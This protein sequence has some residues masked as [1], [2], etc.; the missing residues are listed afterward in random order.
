[1]SNEKY[2]NTPCALVFIGGEYCEVESFSI[3]LTANGESSKCD[4]EIL[5]QAIDSTVFAK[6]A[7]DQSKVEVIVYAGYI[8]D[9][10]DSAGYLA[11]VRQLIN[12]Q[13]ER[14]K[15]LKKRF[16]G[17]VA[18]PQWIFGEKSTV[19][20]SCFDWSQLLREYKW[21]KNLKDGDTEISRVISSIQGKLGDYKI[22]ADS[23]TGSQRLGE[24]D[25]D[26]NSRVYRAEGKSIWDILKEC[27]TKLNKNIFIEGRT[28]YITKYKDKPVEWSLYYLSVSNQKNLKTG[29]FFTEASF[30]YGEIGESS[31]GNVV[32]DLYSSKITKKGTAKATYVR[33]PENAPI[34]QNTLYIKR[35]AKI[36]AEESE[37]RTMAENI[38]KKY[39]KKVMTGDVQLPFANNGIDVYDLV[40]FVC[41]DADNQINFIKDYYFSVNSINETYGNGGY[42]QTIEIETDPDIS[43]NT[44][45]YTKLPAPKPVK[46][47]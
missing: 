22:K 26:S 19:K 35:Y 42:T 1:M 43:K 25:A 13:S 18:Q 9:Q 2:F 45:S 11:Q 12:S 24:R 30:R 29:Q 31:K 34:K 41:D 10:K 37:L 3:D 8:E 21:E 40:R 17:F 46:R 47:K 7:N 27:A 14:T 44:V 32:V 38:Y 15:L 4:I 20:L 5:M 36:N 6:Q 16:E 28:I 33:Y 39:A 23:Y